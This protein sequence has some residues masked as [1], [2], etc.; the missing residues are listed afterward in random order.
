MNSSLSSVRIDKWLWAARFYKTR[1]LAVKAIKNSKVSVNK[2]V[3][4]PASSVSTDDLVTIKNGL[5]QTTII[6]I[7]L[8][9]QR[10]PAKVAQTLYQETH[11]SFEQRKKLKDDLAAQPKIVMDKRKPDKY[12]VRT[13]RALKRGE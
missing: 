3:V 12:S 7:T 6:I 11:E 10:G 9:E 4:K 1:A 13:N 2:Q 5:F 8:S